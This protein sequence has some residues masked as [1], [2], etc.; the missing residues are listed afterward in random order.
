MSD[1]KTMRLPIINPLPD[2]QVLIKLDDGEFRHELQDG[3]QFYIIA[4]DLGIV[5]VG[6]QEKEDMIIDVFS[7]AFGV[8][9]M[10][11][12]RMKFMKVSSDPNQLT[13]YIEDTEPGSEQHEVL[14]NG[15]LVKSVKTNPR[16]VK[17]SGTDE[18]FDMIK[19]NKNILNIEKKDG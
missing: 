14:S 1:S 13:E 15:E 16:I 4:T 7:K 17:F 18:T 8:D 12:L 6:S 2:T 3:N 5:C 19:V 9:N 10:L 11:N